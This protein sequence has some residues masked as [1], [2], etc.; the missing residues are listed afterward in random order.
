MQY[1]KRDVNIHRTRV[2]TGTLARERH[3]K[4]KQDHIETYSTI[5]VALHYS[6]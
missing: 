1:S 6:C 3:K 4:L 5:S 2:R